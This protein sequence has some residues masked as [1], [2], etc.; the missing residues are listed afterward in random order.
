[1]TE[2]RDAGVVITGAGHGIG[3]AM[4]RRFADGGARVVVNDLDQPA[5]ATVAAEIGGTAIA[6]DAAAPEDLIATA[7]A[8][9]GAIDIYCANAGVPTGGSEQA[10]DADW[11]LA[12]QVNVM[13][14][15]RASRALTGDWLERGRG[16]FL[17]TVSAAGLLT[18]LG[19]APY[20]V[21]KHA[22]LAFAEWMRITY[23]HKGI[24][25]QAL[26]PL[27]VRTNM[28]ADIGAYGKALLEPDAIAPERV[29]DAV[30]DSLAD[31][32]FLILPHPQVAKMYANRAADPRRW[33]EALRALQI[34]IESGPQE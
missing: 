17:S 20:A 9:L 15:V 12:W 26:C 5:A 28:I 30:A 22:V 19:A 34:Q 21:T 4:A 8:E 3:A 29:A 27:G 10:T 14:H 11:D 7:R 2:L 32:P 33:Q 1:M 31:G 25:V 6:G 16:H 18:M 13:A 24:T 23:G